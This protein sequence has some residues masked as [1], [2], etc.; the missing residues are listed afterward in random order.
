MKQRL[1][2][3]TQPINIEE[4]PLTRLVEMSIGTATIVWRFLKKLKIVLPYDPA[5]PHLG[6]YLEET[7]IQKDTLEFLSWLSRNESY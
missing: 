4:N 6:T 1:R 3:V 2:K 7:I 5:V